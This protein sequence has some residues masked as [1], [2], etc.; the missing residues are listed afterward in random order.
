MEDFLNLRDSEIDQRLYQYCRLYL[1]SVEPAYLIHGS[2]AKILP[3]SERMLTIFSET[4]D[5]RFQ[6]A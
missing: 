4:F 6:V 2:V 5:E 3:M 1:C